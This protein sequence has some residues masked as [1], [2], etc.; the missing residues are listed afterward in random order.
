VD[1]ERFQTSISSWKLTD[2]QKN[3]SS[4]FGD[5]SISKK[6]FVYQ[7]SMLIKDRYITSLTCTSTGQIL[8]SLSDGSIH[9]ELASQDGLFKTSCIGDESIDNH[10]WKIADSLESEDN[11]VD[12]ITDIALSPNETHAIYTYSSG[13]LGISRITTDTMNDDY[14]KKNTKTKT[15]TH[16]VY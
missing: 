4:S 3:I 9:M 7:S 6:E 16:L 15:L 14:G 8:V 13:R 11:C 12:F 10:F 5:I 1:N 2:I